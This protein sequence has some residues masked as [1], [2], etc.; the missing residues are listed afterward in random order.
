MTDLLNL[1][2]EGVRYAFLAFN[3]AA[4]DQAYEDWLRRVSLKCENG[5]YEVFANLCDASIEQSIEAEI[6][7]DDETKLRS[8]CY[9]AG[10]YRA[11]L[12]AAN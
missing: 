11:K 3:D 12:E 7:F 2:Q 8:I 4:N 10:Y 1:P 9:A 5:Q 6:P